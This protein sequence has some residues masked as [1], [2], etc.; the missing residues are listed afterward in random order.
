M[1]KTENSRACTQCCNN[2]VDWLSHSLSHC[3]GCLPPSSPCGSCPE[4]WFPGITF[5]D[6]AMLRWYWITDYPLVLFPLE[7]FW[8]ATDVSHLKPSVAWTLWVSAHITAFLGCHSQ[9]LADHLTVPVRSTHFIHNEMLTATRKPFCSVSPWASI[10][11]PLPLVPW[12]GASASHLV[13]HDLVLSRVGKWLHPLL[14]PTEQS[15]PTL[16]IQTGILAIW[17]LSQKE[18]G[19]NQPWNERF[20]NSV[21]RMKCGQGFFLKSI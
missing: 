14:G 8:T 6:P 15:P 5:E 16:F 2:A 3:Q 13:S 4:F 9:A 7:A 11:A 10:H 19:K 12:W 18:R 21:F 20:W 1:R 17:G